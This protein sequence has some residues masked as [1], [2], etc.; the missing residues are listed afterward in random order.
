MQRD[1]VN[2]NTPKGPRVFVL[3]H[4]TTLGERLTVRIG[5][6]LETDLSFS[7]HSVGLNHAIFRRVAGERWELEDQGST[8]GTVVDDLRLIPGVPMAIETKQGLRFGRVQLPF[9]SPSDS[10]DALMAA[11]GL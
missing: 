10:F 8:D 5:R 1:G 9:H 11:G 3:R 7:D 2:I 6:T 4:P